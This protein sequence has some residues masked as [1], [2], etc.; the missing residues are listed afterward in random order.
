ML[1]WPIQFQILIFE[2]IVAAS[3]QT[4]IVT[5]K[6]IVYDS[7]EVN[8]NDC[9]LFFHRILG[10]TLLNHIPYTED[11]LKIVVHK[12]DDDDTNRMMRAHIMN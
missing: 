11:S 1:N 7:Y 9:I 5:I 3:S 2:I 6:I 12:I 8:F 10:Y 4:T